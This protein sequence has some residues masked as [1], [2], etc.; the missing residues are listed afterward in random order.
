MDEARLKT[1]FKGVDYNKEDGAYHS[2]VYHKAIIHRLGQYELACDA[3]LAF[4]EVSRL[5]GRSDPALKDVGDGGARGPRRPQGDP[6]RDVVADT[7]GGVEGPPRWGRAVSPRAPRV[8][9]AGGH[10][11]GFPNS[12]P[13]A[14]ARRWTCPASPS[15]R[16]MPTSADPAK[17]FPTAC[18]R[19]ANPRR[20]PR[21]VRACSGPTTGAAAWRPT[22][23]PR[24]PKGAREGLG[25]ARR[26]GVGIPRAGGGLRTGS[27]TGA[28]A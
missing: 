21:P 12:P 27:T 28:A 9:G 8:D 20:L 22:A 1:G 6:G 23:R 16:E 26:E 18:T 3:A 14:R 17:A 24:D 7:G 2:K 10:R 25:G 15:P 11:A 19:A 13:P 4:D 5:L